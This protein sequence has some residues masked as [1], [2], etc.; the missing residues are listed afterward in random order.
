MH[1]HARLIGIV[2]AGI[3]VAVM[4]S[5]TVVALWSNLPEF[6][7]ALMLYE[8]NRGNQMYQLQFFVATSQLLFVA[9]GAIVGALFAVNGATWIALASAVSAVQPAPDRRR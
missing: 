8:R 1:R 2:I 4:I 9:G 7:K 3:G 6:R 5:F